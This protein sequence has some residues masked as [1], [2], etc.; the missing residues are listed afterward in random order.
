[1]IRMRTPLKSLAIAATLAM[2]PLAITGIGLATAP[3]ALAAGA[4]GQTLPGGQ[5]LP[6]ILRDRVT[7]ESD[8]LMLS[9][10]FANIPVE[11]DQRIAE[12]PQP[13]ERMVLGARQ[14][15][16]YAKAFG[17]DW[18]PDRSKVAVTIVRASL[19]VPMEMIADTLSARLAAEYVEDDF[20]LDL[21]GRTS[22]LFVPSNEPLAL[23]VHSLTYEPRT[24][25]FEASVSAD[26][27]R[28]I[29]VSGKVVPMTEVPMLRRHA[30][31]G[32]V[33][34][35]DMVS[36]QRVSTRV[37]SV[38]TVS[39][40]EDI[41]GLTARRPLTAG[42]PIRLTDLKPNLM[43]N[44]GD[45]ITLMVRT[46]LMTLTAR[47]RALESGTKGAVIRVRNS[48]SDKIVEARIAAP[49]M[50]IVEPASLA[51]LMAVNG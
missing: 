34:S 4:T 23:R 15:W 20:D 39:R 28:I 41:I 2:T 21:F 25:R 48:H 30:M 24:K 22:K 36:W 42:I 1:M 29:Q 50:A 26:N 35:E 49:E 14:I 5:E 40:R 7:V 51:S 11:T 38:T 13:G 33:I 47:G 32:Q 9:D 31:P 3:A 6:V 12:A 17:L 27:G 10:L 8:D 45:T 44:K 19:E 16:R 46:G 18:Q 37:A 43:I